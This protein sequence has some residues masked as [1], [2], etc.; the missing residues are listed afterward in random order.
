MNPKTFRSSKCLFFRFST[1]SPSFSS[2]FSLISF[3]I[4]FPK[5]I[6]CS[7]SC[8]ILLPTT[9]R[10]VH[11]V[12]FEMLARFSFLTFPSMQFVISI[13]LFRPHFLLE[14]DTERSE[15]VSF[16]RL[17]RLSNFLMLSVDHTLFPCIKWVSFKNWKM[18]KM[19]LEGRRENIVSFHPS[20]G[21][22]SFLFIRIEFCLQ[23]TVF[24]SVF[25]QIFSR[26]RTF[27]RSWNNNSLKLIRDRS[28]FQGRTVIKNN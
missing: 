11:F 14:T 25:S 23:W 26:L 15:W 18:R 9:A 13:S 6:Y 3:L 21:Y 27:F 16:R 1:T 22:P 10:F 2:F 12:P 17:G 20:I 28:L 19:R 4:L 24:H 5:N 8:P 7:L